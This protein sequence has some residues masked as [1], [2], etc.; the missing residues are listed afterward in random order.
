MVIIFMK[1]RLMGPN[2]PLSSGATTNITEF[3]ERNMGI[4][5]DKEWFQNWKNYFKTTTATVDVVILIFFI[6]KFL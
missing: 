1:W 6:L 3:L 4:A 2:A 5:M